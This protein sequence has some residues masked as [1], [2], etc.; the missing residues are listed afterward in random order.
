MSRCVHTTACGAAALLLACLLVAALPGDCFAGGTLFRSAV[1]GIS[2]DTDGVLRTASLK[3]RNSWRERLE[4]EVA[5]APDALQRPVSLRMISL[6]GIEQALRE[7]LSGTFGDLPDE[8]RFLAGIQRL[9]YVLL[10]PQQNDIVLAGPGE[11][12][13]IDDDGNVLGITTGRPVLH[14]EDL[15]VAMRYAENARSGY[16]ISCSIDP[17]EEG[18][19]QFDAYRSRLRTIRD[20]DPQRA[21]RAMGPQQITLH[22]LPTDS[23]LARI[24]VAADYRMKQYAMDLESPPVR[25]LPS[26]LDLLKSKRGAA[27]NMNP[28]WWLACN[29]EP[30]ARSEDGLAWELRGQ[31]VKALTEDEFISEEGDV[32]G[33]GRT[34]PAA[35]RWA[36]LLTNKYEELARKDAVFGELRNVMDMCVVAAL[37]QKEEMLSQVG[38]DLPLLANQQTPLPLGGLNAPR[39]VDTQCS[40]LRVGNN[41]VIAA[42]GGVQVA[43]WQVVR[44]VQSDPRVSQIRARA[45]ADNRSGWWWN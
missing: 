6:R 34:N 19:R 20:F 2:I 27:A 39:T 43:S 26:F 22:G 18:R 14:L 37:I 11:G 30:L 28:R 45:K 1:G 16:G 17:S 29:Y 33:S 32:V 21:E 38:L 41:Y 24:L 36:E 13:R 3:I 5:T 9:Q 42:S 7:N 4:A 10:Y 8:I 35:Q 40:V 15:I 25:G 12:W 23:R 44:Q 31:G